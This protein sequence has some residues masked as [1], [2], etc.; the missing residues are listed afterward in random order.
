MVGER[1]LSV[2]EAADALGV[3]VQRVRQLIRAGRLA[4][5]RSSA[6]WLVLEQAV[7]GRLDNV[8][9]GRPAEPRTVWAA[10]ALLAAA[11]DQV[12]PSGEGKQA[13]EVVADRRLRHRVLR[14]LDDLPDPV[15]DAAPWMRLLSSRGRVRRMW[16]HPGVVDRVFADRRVARSEELTVVLR[17][18]GLAGGPRRLPGYVSASDVDDLIRDYRLLDDPDGQ[19]VLLVVP[20]DVPAE[21]APVPGLPVPAPAAI[22]DLL[23]EDDVRARNSAVRRLRDIQQA[24]REVGWLGTR[25]SR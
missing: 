24:L 7:A 13:A 10:I 9:N 19:V 17:G 6:G 20:A 12:S 16:A 25:R 1:A 8:S 18:E 5:R 4:A 22:A 3:S 2:R 21:L 23:A 14:M 11:S 15:E